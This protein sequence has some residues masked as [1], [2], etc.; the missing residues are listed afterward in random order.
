MAAHSLTSLL[1]LAAAL[2]AGRFSDT[3]SGATAAHPVEASGADLP[4]LV[5]YV[6]PAA[7]QPD[8]ALAPRPL[9]MPAPE[10]YPEYHT[11]AEGETLAEVAARYGVDA[12]TLFWSN[13]LEDESFLAAGRELRIPRVAGLPHTVQPGETVESIAA[14]YGVSPDAILLF[15]P[16]RLRPGEQPRPGAELFIPG[17][18]QPLPPDIADVAGLRAV[19][20]GSVREAETNLRTGPGRAYDR[21]ASLDAGHQL[22]PVARHADW[23]K[24]DAGEHGSG[25]VRADLLWLPPG[26]LEALPETTDFPPPPPRWVW[27][28]W[29][30]LT[31][32]FGWRRVPYRSFH[33]GLDIAN[34]AGTP[35]LAARGGRVVEAGWCSGYGYCVRIDHGDGVRTI[36]GH[37]LRKPSVR[38]GDIVDAGDQIGLM[39]M[40][41]DRSGGG[42]ATG[43]HLH[44]TV[45]VNGHPVD[46]LKFLP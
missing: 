16:N 3:E 22:R 24:V 4:V 46:P 23:V 27:P 6:L 33:N 8:D 7:A 19:T 17:G 1:V 11:L 42:F 34:R 18:R 32:P 9:L 40:T 31:S 10:T 39:G 12:E 2:L 13:G 37:L 14:S 29:G 45:T 25:W 26:A 5:S 44:F 43:V 28:T 20:A 41:Y 15:L 36:Y 38:V 30:Q 21:I 35:I